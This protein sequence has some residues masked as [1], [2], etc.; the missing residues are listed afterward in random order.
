M[1]KIFSTQLQGLFNKIM[2][3]EDLAVEDGARLL[4]QAV[5]GE[6][7][8]YI[9]GYHELEAIEIEA[10]QGVEPLPSTS[11]LF[12]GNDIA[13]ITERDRVLILSRSS[14]DHEAIMLAKDCAEKGISTVAISSLVKDQVDSLAD[15]VDVHI[16]SK[17][18]KPLIPD[19]DGNRFGFPSIMTALFAY[20]SLS[21]TLK[22][23]IK[24]YE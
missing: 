18:T 19:E 14:A 1:M 15:F 22:E 21:F 6:G 10:T 17:L 23:I 4:A 9:K 24:E 11:V 2:E 12:I 7:T 8:I 13:E 3:Q 20:Y 5:M 16:D